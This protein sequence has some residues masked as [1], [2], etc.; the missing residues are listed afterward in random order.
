MALFSKMPIQHLCSTFF[1]EQISSLSLTL[2]SLSTRTWAIFSRHQNPNSIH[3][4]QQFHDQQPHNAH[5]QSSSVEAIL[6]SYSCSS[7]HNL[8]SISSALNVQYSSRLSITT[9]SFFIL[10]LYTSTTTC[11][12]RLPSSSNSTKRSPI[13]KEIT[14]CGRGGR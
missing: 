5:S 12:S 11:V 3:I 10:Q 8:S 14:C 9:D 6:A 1:N 7:F 13:E 4:Y 2:R